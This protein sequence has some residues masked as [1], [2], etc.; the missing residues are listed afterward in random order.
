MAMG[1]RGKGYDK[2]KGNGKMGGFLC[3]ELRAS[4]QEAVSGES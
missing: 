1:Q 4:E 2:Q 3:A